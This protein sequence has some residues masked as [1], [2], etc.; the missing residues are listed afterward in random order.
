M[1]LSPPSTT[2]RSSQA[3]PATSMSPAFVCDRGSGAVWVDASSG[4]S[5]ISPSASTTPVETSEQTLRGSICMPKGTRNRCARR[6]SIARA[7]SRWRLAGVSRAEAGDTVSCDRQ[8]DAVREVARD[9]VCHRA[10]GVHDPPIDA[11]FDAWHPRCRTRR[12]PSI[13][14]RARYRPAH[15]RSSSRFTVNARRPAWFRDSAARLSSTATTRSCRWW[16]GLRRWGCRQ[17]R[18]PGAA[19]SD[20]PE[21]RGWRLHARTA[22]SV[23]P[24]RH[25]VGGAMARAWCNVPSLRPLWRGSN[26]ALFSCNERDERCARTC[27]SDAIPGGAGRP[28]ALDWRRGGGV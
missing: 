9:I 12:G 20:C 27:R 15:R 11:R 23:S 3:R 17:R 1:R 6:L 16:R 2:P 21:R 28:A 24:G 8:V 4:A 10:P 5:T 18:T 14:P 7:L 19:S 22:D 26:L 13:T 25:A